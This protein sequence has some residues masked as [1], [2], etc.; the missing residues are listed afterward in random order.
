LPA[1][2]R[3]TIG[4][5]ARQ[6]VHG[7]RVTPRTA[8]RTLAKQTRRVLGHPGSRKH[9]LRRHNHLERRFHRGVGRRMARPHT[10]YGYGRRWRY[11]RYPQGYR[12]GR[13]VR[14]TTGPAPGRVAPPVAAPA[15]SGPGYVAPAPGVRTGRM[16]GGQC[17]CGAAQQQAPAYCR[18]C[19]QV[20]R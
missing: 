16:V 4:S 11:G 12:G 1:I 6:A 8:I 9:A 7:R 3:R 19:G 5:I 13:V 17:N 18:C 15:A 20:I 2:A 10:H 14:S